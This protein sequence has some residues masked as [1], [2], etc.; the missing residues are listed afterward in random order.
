MLLGTGGGKSLKEPAIIKNRALAEIWKTPFAPAFVIASETETTDSFGRIKFNKETPSDFV[1]SFILCC[2]PCAQVIILIRF[3]F[4]SHNQTHGENRDNGS[5]R[6][7]SQDTKSIY[8]TRF[9]ANAQS[10]GK[11]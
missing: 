4:F 2:L 7:Q 8:R 3:R 5:D 6:S 9:R 10:H 1:K 11:D